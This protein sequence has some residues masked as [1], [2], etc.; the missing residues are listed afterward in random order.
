[1]FIFHHFDLLLLLGF[2]KNDEKMYLTMNCYF[3]SA[4]KWNWCYESTTVTFFVPSLFHWGIGIIDVSNRK[5]RI[6][7]SF[8]NRCNCW[9]NINVII[10]WKNNLWTILQSYVSIFYPSNWLKLIRFS[11][12]I[13]RNRYCDQSSCHPSFGSSI[14]VSVNDNN[15]KTKP[16]LRIFKEKWKQRTNIQALFLL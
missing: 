14:N 3:I 11:F 10:R 9:S 13:K 16:R 7:R 15:S 12:E 5:W 2:I 8:N 6:V 1:M 4:Q